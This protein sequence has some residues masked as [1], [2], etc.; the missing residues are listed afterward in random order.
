MVTKLQHKHMAK[1]ALKEIE[2]QSPEVRQAAKD[3]WRKALFETLKDELTHETQTQM[4]SRMD[5]R[6]TS[7]IQA[8]CDHLVQNHDDFERRLRITNASDGYTAELKESLA[9][10]RLLY[11]QLPKFAWAGAKE[12]VIANEARTVAWV[13]AGGYERLRH[14]VDHLFAIATANK[15]SNPFI[16]FKNVEAD[17]NSN[18]YWRSIIRTSGGARY[19]LCFTVAIA[20]ADQ[21]SGVCY[22]VQGRGSELDPLATPAFL[23]LL[24]SPH[25][26]WTARYQ[27]FVTALAF[28]PADQQPQ[29]LASLTEQNWSMQRTFDFVQRALTGAE[30]ETALLEKQVSGLRR[31]LTKAEERTAKAEATNLALMENLRAAASKAA[32]HRVQA[33]RPREINTNDVVLR[34]KETELGRLQASLSDAT[35]QLVLTRELLSVL[36]EPAPDVC[37]APVHAVGETKPD[38]WRVVFVGGHERLHT[39]LRKQMRRAIF[40]HPDQSQFSSGA[41]DGVDAVVF[42]IGYCCHALAYR[43]ADEVRRRGLRAGYSNST[44]VEMVLDEVRAVLFQGE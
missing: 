3:A 41:F 23:D 26:F 25:A 12:T 2:A 44:N 4:H 22:G 16:R 19:F 40:L 29:F 24:K 36:L 30:R 34:E 28:M 20:I 13:E 33:E 38:Q 7:T 8:R 6:A 15:F 37:A 32:V 17:R 42:S 10:D 18:A 5:V 43:A 39:K 21:L 1:A 14:T 35:D 11:E 9:Q 27:P 31:S